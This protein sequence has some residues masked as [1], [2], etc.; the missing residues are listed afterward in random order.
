MSSIGPLVSTQWL[1]ERLGDPGI[2]VID[3]SWRM[4][5]DAPARTAYEN[6][7]IEGAVFFDLDEIADRNS[8]LPHMAPPPAQFEM[9]IGA[10]GVSERDTVVIYDDAGCFSA[11]RVWW[12][13]RAMG[14]RNVAVLDGGLPKWLKEDHPVTSARS[15][16]ASAVYRAS[17][18]P[19]I[20]CDAAALRAK[21]SES[22]ALVLDARSQ[23]RFL[24]KTPEPREGLRSGHMPGAISLPYGAVLNNDQTFLDK[25]QLAKV[26]ASAGVTDQTAVVTT[27]GSGVTAAILSLAL[28]LTAQSNHKLYDGSWTEWGDC[29]HDAKEFPVVAGKEN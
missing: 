15:T 25:A 22:D 26:F 13:F 1:A 17:F 19:D 27:C 11:A 10:L 3:G 2:K 24:A 21:L 4:P 18:K 29:R 20:V 23:D 14:H 12:T 16:T 5:G 6:R 7:H 28:E 8:D 9:Q